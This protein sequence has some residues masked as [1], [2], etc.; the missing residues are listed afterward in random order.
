[1]WCSLLQPSWTTLNF[2]P[3]CI[4]QRGNAPP[5]S[6]ESNIV[7]LQILKRYGVVLTVGLLELALLAVPIAVSGATRAKPLLPTQ[8][9]VTSSDKYINAIRTYFFC[10]TAKCKKA[11]TT[12]KAAAD[13]AIGGIKSEITLMKAD[14][15][16]ASQ[17]AIVAKYKV[18]AKALIAAYT[19]FPKKTDA[20]SV[21]NNIGIIYYQS[22]NLG[23]DDYLLGCAQTKT[24]VIFKEW[25]VG[26]VGVAYAMQVDTQAETTTA[27]ASTILSANKSLVAEAASMK[28]DA[29][30]PNKKFNA[31]VV[32]FAASQALDSRDSILILEGKG[33]SV[34]RA[35]LKALATKLTA[36]FKTLSTLQNELAK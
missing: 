35:D 15:V 34:T 26:V 36:E 25:S 2:N 13:T 28:S 18:D 12:A 7:S 17:A 24:S 9:I 5:H 8:Q 30:G 16:P 21:A 20:D 19:A 11:V 4:N 31:L 10:Q 27:P 14:A 3:S 6:K 32:Q 22:S 29:N 23:S 1:M 33:K